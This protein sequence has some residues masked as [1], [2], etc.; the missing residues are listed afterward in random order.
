MRF[1]VIVV[2][3]IPQPSPIFM[4]VFDKWLFVIVSFC[5]RHPTG[6]WRYCS[7]QYWSRGCVALS[8]PINFYE[9]KKKCQGRHNA[10]GQHFFWLWV[11]HLLILV[12]FISFFYEQMILYIEDS[13]FSRH[14]NISVRCKIHSFAELC[15]LSFC[16]LLGL[17][18]QNKFLLGL[19]TNS[20]WNRWVHIYANFIQNFGRKQRKWV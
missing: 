18:T 17:N 1:F 7:F 19:S 15:L 6:I 3:K 20:L 16:L 12:S 4:L 14:W 2:K 10:G 8:L 11:Q 5:L 13:A 9:W